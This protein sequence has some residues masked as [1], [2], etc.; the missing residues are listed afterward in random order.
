M[1]KV[2]STILTLTVLA[3]SLAGSTCFAD[4]VKSDKDSYVQEQDRREQFKFK[5]QKT[6]RVAKLAG[7]VAAGTAAVTGTA[8]AGLKLFEEEL[9]ES[10]KKWLPGLS[11]KDKALHPTEEDVN[12]SK[13]GQ[14]GSP[15]QPA[16]VSSNVIG[17]L[18][19]PN[20]I[21]YQTNTTTSFIST[22]KFENVES[23]TVE[24][25]DK[26]SEAITPETTAQDLEMPEDVS[27]K[28]IENNSVDYRNNSSQNEANDRRVPWSATF[29]LS[30]DGPKINEGKLAEQDKGVLSEI[31]DVIYDHPVAS[32]VVG[33]VMGAGVY[34]FWPEIAAT[35]A[36]I[37]IFS[38]SKVRAWGNKITTFAMTSIGKM[39]GLGREAKSLAMLGINKVWEMFIGIGDTEPQVKKIDIVSR[40]SDQ[41]RAGF[42][43]LRTTMK[44]K[45]ETALADWFK[46][47]HGL[48]LRREQQLL[49]TIT[50][51][52]VLKTNLFENEVKQLGLT[53]ENE[54]NVMAY[55][56]E[57]FESE[58]KVK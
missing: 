15:E 12:Q 22:E 27:Q 21:I 25:N 38:P 39:R 2:I 29:L 10:I 13:S 1:K 32:T 4:K 6:G 48:W 57:L 55:L 23:V 11:N 28:A 7:C 47:L 44:Y 51:P 24:L 58:V 53:G 20:E 3:T 8:I 52:E 54:R 30:E 14:S 35:V 43:I 56:I 41:A 45:S 34:A 37:A 19:S 50:N 40:L 17:R 49:P 16:N 33:V 5:Q 36:G 18:S 26:A 9:P 42:N 46:E 31:G